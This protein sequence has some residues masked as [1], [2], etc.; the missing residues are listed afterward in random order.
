MK[1]KRHLLLTCVLP[2]AAIYLIDAR[3]QLPDL[4]SAEQDYKDGNYSQAADIYQ[5]VLNQGLGSGE[6]YYNLGNCYYKLGQYGRAILNYER[7]R[8]LLG[9][10]PDLDVNL[11]L[12]NLMVPDRIEPLPR[13]FVMQIFSSVA[14]IFSLRGWA[15]LLVICEWI[16][17]FCLAGLQG[18][19]HPRLRRWLAQIFWIGAAVLIVSAGF[20]WARKVQQERTVEAVVIENRV[21]VRSAPEENSTELFTLHDGVKFRILRQVPGWAEIHLA[22][23]KQGWMPK[24]AFEVI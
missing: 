7:A 3:A 15:A 18:L 22:D 1:P 6:V 12:A 16:L 9:Q 2:L 11:K 14:Q 24:A 17:L 19:R 20:F 21:E 23:G 8:R 13:L 5:R 10:D 4:A